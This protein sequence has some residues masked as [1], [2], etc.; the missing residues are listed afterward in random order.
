[1]DY[2]QPIISRFAPTPTGIFQLGI[3]RNALYVFLLTKKTKGK[4]I[5]RIDDTDPRCQK[6][7]EEYMI[8]SLKWLGLEPDEIYRQSERKGIYKRYIEKLITGKIGSGAFL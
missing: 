5:L 1:M 4:F 7:Y 3:I 2:S 8:D 6:K